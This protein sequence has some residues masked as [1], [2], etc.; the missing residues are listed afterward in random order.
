MTS[1]DFSTAQRLS[2]PSHQGLASLPPYLQ[3]PHLSPTPQTQRTQ[4]P[5][6]QRRR[7]IELQT[8][9]TQKFHLR[10][11]L[12]QRLL[13]AQAEGNTQLLQTLRREWAE[14]CPDIPCIL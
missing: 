5:D 2:P 6:Q 9:E 14:L 8:M 12:C 10:D 1:T 4:T 13:K 11:R 3:R 7:E